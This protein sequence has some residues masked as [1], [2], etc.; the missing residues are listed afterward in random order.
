MRTNTHEIVCALDADHLARVRGR[1]ITL[2]VLEES[3]R[4]AGSP[5]ADV[6]AALRRDAEKENG[7]A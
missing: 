7:N 1:P 4:A 2:R 5:M 6:Y 3:H